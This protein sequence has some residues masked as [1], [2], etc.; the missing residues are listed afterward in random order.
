MEHLA[1]LMG[2]ADTGKLARR[3]WME[4]EQTFR[5]RFW[6]AKKGFWADSLDSR[7]LSR[8]ESY[9]SHAI[10]WITPFARELIG[11]R[12]EQCADFMARHH[13]FQA[14]ACTRRGTMRSMATE[15]SSGSTIR[16]ALTFRS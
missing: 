12:A 7:N 2:D 11:A 9:P 5:E 8:R 1:G 16:L 4:L 13:A 14:F 3:A 15:T 6:D 10:L